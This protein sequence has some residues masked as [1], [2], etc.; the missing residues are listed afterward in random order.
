MY[1]SDCAWALLSSLRSIMADALSF[2]RTTRSAAR[3]KWTAEEASLVRAHQ[4]D[5]VK[6]QDRAPYAYLWKEVQGDPAPWLSMSP[7]L[8]EKEDESFAF[9]SDAPAEFLLCHTLLD[10]VNQPDFKEPAAFAPL[11]IVDLGEE[12][13]S[14]LPP[15]S[16]EAAAG[17]AGPACND[18]SW[19]I[20][21]DSCCVSNDCWIAFSEIA[22]ILAAGSRV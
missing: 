15:L 17:Y 14:D 4:V 10:R 5:Y 3:R 11:T 13:L 7:L 9:A 12:F 16:A 18:V 20:D 19:P 2:L 21:S 6:D 22:A 1:I 8:V